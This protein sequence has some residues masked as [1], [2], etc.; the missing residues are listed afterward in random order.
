MGFNIKNNYGPNI[1]VNDGGKV[2]LVQGKNGLWNTADM[3][4][5]D[6]AE[7]V[8]DEGSQ[9]I[10]ED[11]EDAR[12]EIFHFIHPEIEED[13]AWHIHNAIKRL[14]AYQKIPEICSYLKELKQK[15]KVLL[16]SVSTVMY[17]ELVRLGMPN[18]E[19]YTEKHFRNSY[20]K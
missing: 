13:E 1:E 3:A 18:S 6:Y 8:E 7:V 17:N 20:M 19:G 5:A 9:P 2:T 10:L 14:V 4:D 16:P 12:E 11:G 15:G